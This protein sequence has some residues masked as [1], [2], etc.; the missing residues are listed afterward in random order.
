MLNSKTRHATATATGAPLKR[1]NK[2]MKDMNKQNTANPLL[3]TIGYEAIKDLSL[4]QE[5]YD[6][7]TNEIQQAKI[8]LA[9]SPPL[10]A[11]APAA[12]KREEWRSWLQLQITTKQRV[13][14]DLVDALREKGFLV[15]HLPE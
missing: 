12:S 2:V 5:Q 14:M 4:F 1:N 15:E 13:R 7:L 8:Q 3:L 6:K 11:S 9:N 10:E